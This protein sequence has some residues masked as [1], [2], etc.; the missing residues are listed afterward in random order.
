M[1]KTTLLT[2]GA[3]L[4]AITIFAADPAVS[5]ITKS[6]ESDRGISEICVISNS[7]N[8]YII[9]AGYAKNVSGKTPPFLQFNSGKSAVPRGLSTIRVNGIQLRNISYNK[10]NMKVWQDKSKGMAGC[11]LVLNFD[12][13]KIGVRF[14]MTQ[15]SPMLFTR[16][17]PH[18]SSIEPI[19]SITYENYVCPNLTR[20]GRIRWDSKSYKRVAVTGSR[21][22]KG[23]S[24]HNQYITLT[25]QDTQLQLFDS[26]YGKNPGYITFKYDANV[27]SAG[28]HL[29][30]YQTVR[31]T[32]NPAFKEF[33]TAYWAHLAPNKPNSEL[34]KAIKA[35]PAGFKIK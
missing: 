26:E 33:T 2:C 19:K 22:L 6:V 12:G 8:S 9:T 23:P 15:D 32:L 5:R 16:L 21:T 20:D 3:L 17:T 7:M 10:G 18:P 11:E 34:D 35:N 24:K 25:P 1:T 28:V 31:I 30:P 13:A 14:Y 27:K 29:G 4:S